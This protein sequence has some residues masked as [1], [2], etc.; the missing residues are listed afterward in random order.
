MTK[1]TKKNCYDVARYIIDNIEECHRNSKGFAVY[2]Y[3]KDG[4]LG[5]Y[6]HTSG[7][8]L[9]EFIYQEQYRDVP[10]SYNWVNITDWFFSSEPCSELYT[11]QTLANMIYYFYE[12]LQ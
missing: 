2:L 8:G 4:K 9:W 3:E 10:H 7:D 5:G 1:Y 12:V 6:V 11:K